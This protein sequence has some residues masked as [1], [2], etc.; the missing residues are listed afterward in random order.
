MNAAARRLRVMLVDDH[1]VVRTGYRRLMELEGDIDIVAECAN[2]DEALDQLLRLGDG[3][4][5]VVVVDLSLPGRSGLDFIRR[6]A[7]RYPRTRFLVFSMHDSPAMVSQALQSGAGGFVTK[8]SDPAQL[9]ALLRRVA[10]GELN[11]LSDDIAAAPAAPHAQAPHLAL[12]PREFDVLLLLVQ[13]LPLER[14]AQQLHLS[15]KT[16]SNYQTAI[17]HRLG[18]STAVEL[19]RY[20]QQ[21]KLFNP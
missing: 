21:H 17:R 1:A 19:L 12:T 18:V 16:V 20:A 15:S 10:H 11:V 7:P 9:A 5:D 3:A 13:G 2:A 8:N 14:I 4:L 6:A